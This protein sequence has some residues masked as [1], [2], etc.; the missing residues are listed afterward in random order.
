MFAINKWSIRDDS[1]LKY[2]W[3]LRTRK[4][5]VVQIELMIAVVGANTIE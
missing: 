1:F 3:G 5:A 2:A 4:V